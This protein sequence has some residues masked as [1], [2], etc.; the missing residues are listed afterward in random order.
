MGFHRCALSRPLISFRLGSRGNARGERE[1]ERERVALLGRLLAEPRF[2]H[3]RRELT[4]EN[5]SQERARARGGITVKN[6][7]KS[8]A[9][10]QQSSSCR[11]AVTFNTFW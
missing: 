9:R 4:R 7:A 3:S 10:A 5:R 8:D 2:R 1:R 11:A 6:R